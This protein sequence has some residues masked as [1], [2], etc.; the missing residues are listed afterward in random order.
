MPQGALIHDG[1]GGIWRKFR[2]DNT[3]AINAAPWLDALAQR[4]PVGTCRPC[5]GH[6]W[7]G[8]P[9]T[10]GGRQL[11]PATCSACN[12]EAVAPGPAPKRKR[13]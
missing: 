2:L 10:V 1:R 12:R 6:L 4:H 11:Y 13:K 5:G 8:Q 3:R 9:Y 7:P